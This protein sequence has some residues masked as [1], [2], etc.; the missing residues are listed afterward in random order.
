MEVI[1][2][3]IVT[4]FNFIVIYWKFSNGRTAD[5]TLDLGIFAVIAFMFAGT[6]SGLTVG[7]V[8][9]ALVSFYLLIQPPEKLFT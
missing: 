7:M 2:I 8:A 4:A 1:I 3:G 6:I 9:S 5:A